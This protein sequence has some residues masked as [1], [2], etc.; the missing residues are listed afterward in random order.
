MVEA[1]VR[2]VNHQFPPEK[3]E[4][5]PELIQRGGSEWHKE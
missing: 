4:L 5:L 2:P 1:M 3:V